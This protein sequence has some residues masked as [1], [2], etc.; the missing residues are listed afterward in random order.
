MNQLVSSLG[1]PLNQ[2]QIPRE[3]SQFHGSKGW[4]LPCLAS[5][6]RAHFSLGT[7]LTVGKYIAQVPWL[8]GQSSSSSSSYHTRKGSDARGPRKLSIPQSEMLKTKASWKY[9]AL[10]T[11]KHSCGLP[12]KALA[13]HFW[14]QILHRSEPEITLVSQAAQLVRIMGQNSMWQIRGGLLTEHMLLHC[15]T[16]TTPQW[17]MVRNKNMFSDHSRTT[18]KK[19]KTE[20]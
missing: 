8:P 5:F 11:Q 10:E 3:K 1:H 2:P 15:K 16:L 9:F 14:W 13:L 4:W 7:Y 19:V 20:M 18:I 6:T 17:K 12:P